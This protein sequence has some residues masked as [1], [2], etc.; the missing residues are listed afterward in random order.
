MSPLVNRV[1][2]QLWIIL[3]LVFFGAE[4]VHVEP[5]LRAVSQVLFGIP[6]IAWAG[7]RLRGPW[8][9]LDLAVLSLLGVYLLIALMSRDRTESLNTVGLACGYVALFLLLRR[10]A[11]SARRGQ[12]VGAAALGATLT[13]ALNAWLLIDEKLRWYANV[14]G[15]PLEGLTVFP[16]ESVNALPV[17]VLLAVPFVGS[18]PAGV[19]RRGHIA[20]L[21]ASAV[22]VVPLSVGRAGWLSIAVALLAYV[23]MDPASRQLRDKLPTRYRLATILAAGAAGGAALVVMAVPRV[24]S[25]LTESARIALWRQGLAMVADRPLFGS[26]PGTYSWARLE[27]PADGANLLAVRLVHNVPL[28]TL[29]DGGLALLIM[30][31]AVLS[32]WLVAVWARRRLLERGHRLSIAVLIGFATSTVLDDFSYLPALTVMVLTLAALVVPSG[33]GPRWSP[34][35]SIGPLGALAGAALIALV[36]VIGVDVARTHAQSGRDAAVNGD[37]TA[38]ATSFEAAATWH[39]E[40]GGYWLGLGM[41]QSYLED[42]AKSADAYRRARGAAPGDPRA[43]AALGALAEEASEERALLTVAAI[44]TLGDPQYAVRL[45]RAL[46]DEGDRDAAIAAWGQAAS[47]RPSVLRDLLYQTSTTELAQVAK[48]ALEALIDRPRPSTAM[49]DAIRWDIGLAVNELPTDAGPAWQAVRLAL[50]GDHQ[51]AIALTRSTIAAEPF[52][53]RGYWALAA[54]AALECDAATVAHVLGVLSRTFGMPESGDTEQRVRREFVFREAS[55]GPSQPAGV[56]APT[57]AER[58]PWSLVPRPA[59]CS[60]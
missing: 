51:D 29:V 52:D 48:A 21:G 43:H 47:L 10:E 58:W 5:P 11:T 44:Q 34:R 59:T 38:S 37:W 33:I 20:V 36:H 46:A 40:H 56:P 9:R 54:V 4:V 27:Y 23:A 25:A 18:L 30:F 2:F 50:R 14:G 19:V 35:R 41:A 1:V 8:D 49:N 15:A 31:G 53:A 12:I 45:G 13:L 57:N 6:L 32:L 24:G 3:F 7:A 22:V 39:P 26:G 28:Q 60:P 16:W 42:T 17:L 55:L